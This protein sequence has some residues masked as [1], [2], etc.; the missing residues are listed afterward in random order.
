VKPTKLIEM[1][2]KGMLPKN[3]LGSR[4]FTNLFVYEGTDHPHAAQKQETL[5]FDI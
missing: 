2:V 5:K 4:Q 1:A 3:R